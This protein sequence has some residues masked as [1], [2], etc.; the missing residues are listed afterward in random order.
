M[1]VGVTRGNQ[2]LQIEK[3]QKNTMAKRKGTKG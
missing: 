2:K 1:V 3:G